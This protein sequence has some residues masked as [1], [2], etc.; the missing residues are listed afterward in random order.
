VISTSYRPGLGLEPIHLLL[1]SSRSLEAELE[2]A[3]K[4]SEAPA[5]ERLESPLKIPE[6]PTAALTVI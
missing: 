1:N 4:G 6:T 3:S 5:T 2:L